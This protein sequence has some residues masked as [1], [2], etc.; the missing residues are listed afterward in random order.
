MAKVFF[1]YSHDDEQLRDQ[2]EKHLAVLQHQGAIESWHDRK[3]PAGGALDAHIDEQIN[4]AEVILLLV[5]SSFLASRYC[6]SIEM[7]RALERHH[8]GEAKVVPVI[9]RDCD[10]QASPLGGLLAVPKD[11]KAITSW[12]NFDEA[13]TDVA[14]R[15]RALVD[16]IKRSAAAAPAVDSRAATPSA[17]DEALQSSAP[18]RSSNLRLRREFSQLDA[19][20][21][22]HDSFSFMARYFESSLQELQQRHP[23]VEGQFRLVDAH[24]FTAA[25]YRGGRRLSECSI[26]VGGLGRDNGITYSNNAHGGAN[27]FNEML[28][29]HH[30]D[31]ALFFQPLGRGS[32]GGAS[33]QLSQPGAAELFWSML[34]QPLQ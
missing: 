21:F 14:K 4:R 23:D 13:F 3:I 24:H 28:S 29:V 34:I 33:N 30:D 9:L 16:G 12:P 26:R 1:S 19:D 7:K 27:S 15:I 25:V 11:G 22:L 31:Q 8:A 6:Y 10:W 20:R 5:S 18:Q 17:S 2:L 32:F